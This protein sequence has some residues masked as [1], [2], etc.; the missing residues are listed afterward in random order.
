FDA[1][2]RKIVVGGAFVS[3]NGT[4]RNHFTRLNDNG[5]LDGSFNFG[6]LGA[7]ATVYAV[8]ICPTNSLHAGKILIAGD[9]SSVNGVSRPHI[10]R[11]NRDGS[12]DLTFN[13]FAGPSDSVRS[14]AIQG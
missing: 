10:A 9:F 2:G 7:D 6:G 14:L 12:L 3:F 11:L 8:G 1:V 5:T 13:P 4:V